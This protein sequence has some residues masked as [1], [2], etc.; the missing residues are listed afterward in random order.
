[1]Q[2]RKE[3]IHKQQAGRKANSMN[4]TRILQVSTIAVGLGLGANQAHAIIGDVKLHYSTNG[5]INGGYFQIDANHNGSYESTAGGH[6]SGSIGLTVTAG[7]LSK[8]ALGTT[9]YSVCTDVLG[10][11]GQDKWYKA[12]SFTGQTGNDP[13][14]G[15]NNSDAANAIQNAAHIFY[16]VQKNNPG[17][18]STGTSTQKSALQLAV[19]E[20]LYDTGDITKGFNLSNG[21]F[22]DYQGN[23]AA[24]NQ[25]TAWINQ[26]LVI[27]PRTQT[28]SG[29]LLVPLTS[30]TGSVDCYAQELLYNIC[31]VPEPTTVVAGALLLLPF[32]MSTL[33]SLRKKN[34]A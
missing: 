32:G 10:T 26:Y 29:T 33:R 17:L 24:I 34:I 18:M 20:C 1:M 16:M 31:P 19:W 15:Y 23:S 5:G 28:Y 6:W 7:S 9:F 8:N 3:C 14:W 12:E 4:I 11:L 21:E 2:F 25:A 27:N 22:R 30:R 13:K